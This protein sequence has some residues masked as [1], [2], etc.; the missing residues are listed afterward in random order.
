VRGWRGAQEEVSTTSRRLF[1]KAAAASTVLLGTNAFQAE[2][3]HR[4]IKVGFLGAVHSHAL[5]KWKVL[6]A[7][8]A[9]DLVGVTED[10]P[11][12]RATFEKLG[13]K[14]LSRDALLDASDAVVV[15]SAV[16]DHARDARLAL[17]AGKH[18]HVE[19]P[20]AVTMNEL[21]QLVELA[22][23][24]DR[25]LQV[26]YMWRYHPGF[27]AIFEAAHKR[28]LGDIYLVRAMI[29]TFVP[30]E[31]R[32]EWAEFKG[33]GMFELGCHVID[34]TVRLLG[35]PRRVQPTLRH[36]AAVDDSLND[37]SG[38]TIEFQRALAV[39]T[40]TTRQP[41]AFPY[42]SFEVF[43][44]NGTAVLKPIEPPVM[45]LDLQAP[46]GPYQ[47]GAQTVHLP[48]YERYIG[49]FAEFATAIRGEKSLRVTLDEELLIHETLLKACEMQ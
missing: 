1:L 38:V 26:G 44:S 31:R 16:R 8:L 40:N 9:F 37:N 5:A 18:V 15:E 11:Q 17:Q 2:P 46:S 10:S 33:G 14:S 6:A 19:K 32:A 24:K 12:A 42:R 21:T 34:A 39:I 4:K 20:P 27:A 30:N 49:D 23:K 41:N 3:S 7:S 22:R 43:G 48:D 36:D 13:A 45:Q 35:R 29:N 25:V 47:S 28:Y